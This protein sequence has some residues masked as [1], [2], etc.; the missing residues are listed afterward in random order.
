MQIEM[1]VPATAQKKG[2]GVL[3]IDMHRIEVPRKG[4]RKFRNWIQEKLVPYERCSKNICKV[5][6]KAKGKGIPIV[7]VGLEHD[8]F[9]SRILEAAGKKRADFTK[10][11]RIKNNGVLLDAFEAEGVAKKFE[12]LGVG[13]LLVCGYDTAW[14]VLESAKGAIR[15]G[16]QVVVSP[17]TMFGFDYI[18]IANKNPLK[19]LVLLARMLARAVYSVFF[20]LRNTQV[21]LSISR[22][23]KLLEENA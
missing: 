3:V 13:T 14:C 15:N 18:R 23:A 12:K 5:V 7:T 17:K 6:K 9:D 2:I 10:P 11:D 20:Y 4:G 1:Q 19:R 8:V 22:I 21:H 16:M